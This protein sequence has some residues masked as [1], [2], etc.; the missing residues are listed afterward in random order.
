MKA[1]ITGGTGFLG[2]YLAREL[3]GRGDEVVLFDVAFNEGLIDQVKD[4]VEFVKGDLSCWPEVLDAIK[5]SEADIIYHCG[6]LLSGSAEELPL[7][8]YEINTLGTW[9]ILEAARLFNV[10]KVLFT[11]TVAS[12]GDHISDPVA[13]TAP[14][15]PKTLYG[16]SKVSSERL[17][18]YYK[19]KF[20]VDFRGIRFPSVIGPGRGPGGASAYSS[21]VFEKPV[22]GEPYEVYV[23]PESCIP[24]LYVKDAVKALI[25][26]GEAD[27]NKLKYRMYN[28][29]GFSPKAK[30]IVDVIKKE[31]AGADIKFEPVKEMVDIVN[32][33]PDALDESEA[34]RDWGWQSDF[35]IRKTVMDFKE[36]LS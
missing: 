13:N 30:E 18:E 29:N 1:L 17:G 16:V 21:L 20:G 8:A 22:L 26:L 28:V 9:Y 11:S 3:V 2:S 10:D 19:G 7:K 24:I 25:Q 23:K 27:E 6:A 32:S 33:W 34:V 36:E 12:F 5:R 15:Y 35:D 14:Q 31:I 4:K